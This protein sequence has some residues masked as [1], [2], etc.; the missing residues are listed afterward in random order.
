L[1]TGL[2]GG[3]WLPSDV[4]NPNFGVAISAGLH[5]GL[6][7]VGMTAQINQVRMTIYYDINILGLSLQRFA[8]T[9]QA[10]GDLV[11][12]TVTSP[13]PGDRFTVQRSADSKTWLPLST[14]PAANSQEETNYAYTDA[15]P[16]NGAGYYRLRIQ[17]PGGK[18]FYS[19]TVGITDDK[20]TTIRC[21]PNPVSNVIH[22]TSPSAIRQLRLTDLQGRILGWQE[23]HAT[24]YDWQ[25]PATG[26]PPG[27][28]FL[29]VDDKVFRVVKK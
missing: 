9:R 8:V 18:V 5:S 25:L 2:W 6:A 24:A 29:Q 12:W 23:P 28:Y 7:S 21:Y 14:I 20:T 1:A 13:G 4:N 11:S 27:I 15:L 10:G 17:E 3:S 22:I 16:L 26:M 19:N